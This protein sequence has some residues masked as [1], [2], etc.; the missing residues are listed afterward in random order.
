M[1]LIIHSRIRRILAALL[2]LTGISPGIG[3]DY[4][5]EKKWAD[6]STPG[7]VVGDPVYLEEAAHHEFLAIYAP[8][9]TPKGAVIVVHGLGV[10]PDW[11]LINVLRSAL[12][13]QGYS[14]LSVQMPVL[15]ADA[16]P[17]AY[18]ATFPEAAERLRL[19]AGYLQSR[20]YKNIALV[21]HSMGSRMSNYFLAHEAAPPI[22][23]WAA[24]GLSGPFASPEKLTLPILDL[25]GE[26]DLPQVLAGAPQRAQVLRKLRGSAQIEAP[27]ADHVFSGKDSELVKYVR[28]F[29]DRTL[30]R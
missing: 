23:A 28:T 27:G 17:E 15:A 13:E 3:A 5:R 29:L 2:L 21:S 7:I 20:G 1:G 4:A 24:I 8:A 10:H 26:K 14:T 12:A 9:P 18:A 6:E 25:Y 11:G 30:K 16:K 19:A 22:K